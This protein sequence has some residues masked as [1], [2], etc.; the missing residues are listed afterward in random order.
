VISPSYRRPRRHRRR[1]GP[2]LAALAAAA[3]LFALGIAVG[4]ALHD[5]PNP[6]LTVTTTKTIVP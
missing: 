2:W 4:S 6:D 3:I 5:N 1:L